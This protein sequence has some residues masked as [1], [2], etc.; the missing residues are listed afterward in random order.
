V[1]KSEGKQRVRTS[2]GQTCYISTRDWLRDDVHDAIQ[3][4]H[5]AYFVMN[6]HTFKVMRLEPLASQSETR[7]QFPVSWT[8]V[9]PPKHH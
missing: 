4:L 7:Q 1:E 8:P 5:K 9:D 3:E 6:C 2:S